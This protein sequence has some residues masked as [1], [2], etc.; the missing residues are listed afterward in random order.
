MTE[1]SESISVSCAVSTATE[2]GST[3]GVHPLPTQRNE[4]LG[5]PTKGGENPTTCSC[6]REAKSVVLEHLD[7]TAPWPGYDVSVIH[8]ENTKRASQSVPVRVNRSSVSFET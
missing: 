4:E 8:V 6:E 3:T 7:G 5:I 2:N 1:D